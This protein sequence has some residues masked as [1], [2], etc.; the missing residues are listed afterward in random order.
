MPQMSV[1][2]GA[3]TSSCR[4]GEVRSMAEGQKKRRDRSHDTRV[5]YF[6]FL[7]HFIIAR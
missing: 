3:R 7:F 6:K 4:H 5:Y 1:V 2:R